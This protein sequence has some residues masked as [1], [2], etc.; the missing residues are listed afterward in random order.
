MLLWFPNH[1]VRTTWILLVDVLIFFRENVHS[2]TYSLLLR[3]LVNDEKEQVKLFSAI[4]TMP[5]VR[6][7]ADWCIRWIESVDC[8]FGTRLVAFAVVEGI[9]FSSSFASIFWTRSRGLM[10]ALCQSNELIARDEGMHT[11]FACLLYHHLDQKPSDAT[12]VRMMREAVQLEH[13]FF[14]GEY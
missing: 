14:E 5:T 12:V 13:A 3:S 9:F 4:D 8:D 11:A 2:E 10:P 1:D 6:A 7:K